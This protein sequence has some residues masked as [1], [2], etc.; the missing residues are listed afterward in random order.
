MG[1]EM[2]IDNYGT[3]IYNYALKL[4]CHPTSAEDLAQETFIKAWQN[5]NQLQ[6]PDAIKSWLRQIC[7]N[8]FLMKIRKEKGYTEISYEK[9][10]VLEK[11][12]YLLTDQSPRPE[13]EVIVDEAIR[14][15]QNGCFLAMARRLTLHQRIAFSL[16]DMF[17]LSPDEVSVLLGISKNAMKG[18]LY[19]ARMNLDAFFHNHCDL[20]D[21]ANPCRCEAWIEFSKFRN[22]LQK[23]AKEHKL[24]TTLDYTKSNYIFNAASRSKINFLYQN[25]PDKKPSSEWYQ[26]VIT[27]TREMYITE[28]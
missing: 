22:N 17:G 11:E 18:L 28:D 6:N 2:L 10:Q 25:I 14:E 26:K 20:L 7:L 16:I 5:I 23:E 27:L 24:V 13:D 4:S 8:T 9:I 21:V 3:Y 15:L 1:I 12:A 19:R